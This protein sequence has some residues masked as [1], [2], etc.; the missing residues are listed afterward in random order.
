[1]TVTKII[2]GGQT[3]PIGGLA[4]L[5]FAQ[6]TMRES[7][8]QGGDHMGVSSNIDPLD[9]AAALKFANK[10]LGALDAIHSKWILWEATRPIA[11]IIRPV[12][13]HL[14]RLT[15]MLH[16]ATADHYA[17]AHD[18]GVIT[19]QLMAMN[20]ESLLKPLM[21]IALARQK[22]LGDGHH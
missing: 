20:N 4:T 6:R 11:T 13:E 9:L 14:R 18:L 8:N 1:M 10:A 12:N 2:S 19:A 21:D 7:T 17:V 15:M 16:D 3:A 22:I 5:V